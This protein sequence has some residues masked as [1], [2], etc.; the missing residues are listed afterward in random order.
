MRS[1]YYFISI[2]DNESAIDDT[3]RKLFEKLIGT[4][5]IFG[6]SSQQDPGQNGRSLLSPQN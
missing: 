5:Q 1:Q 6:K 4:S 3:K 2:D